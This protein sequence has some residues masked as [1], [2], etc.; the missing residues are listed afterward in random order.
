VL[1]VRFRRDGAARL[2][3]IFARGHAGWADEGSDIVCAAVAALLQAAWLGLSDYARI[4]LDAK[5]TKGEL[6]LRWSDADRGRSD[7]AAIAATAELAIMQIARQ[8]PGHVR[9]LAE[10][11]TGDGV[12]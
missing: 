10:A 9:Y 12:S 8:Y 5:R 6:S 1:E 2:S 3:S 7:V 11:E 4:E